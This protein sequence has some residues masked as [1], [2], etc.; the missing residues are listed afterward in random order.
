MKL[1]TGAIMATARVVDTFP[2]SYFY[3]YYFMGMAV[4]PA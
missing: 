3:F 4:L 1:K 2:Q